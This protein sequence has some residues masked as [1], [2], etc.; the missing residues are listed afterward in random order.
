MIREVLKMGDPVLLQ[1]AAEVTDFNTPALTELL[2]ADADR[3]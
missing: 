1:K 3:T 2:A